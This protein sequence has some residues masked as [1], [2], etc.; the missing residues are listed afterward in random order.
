MDVTANIIE[1]KWKKDIQRI[2]NDLII[3][4][5]LPDKSLHIVTNFGRDKKKVTSYSLCIYEP[6]YPP[7]L[8]SLSEDLSRNSVILNIKEHAENL[9]FI[10][11]AIQFRDIDLPKNSIVKELKSDKTNVHLL[12]PKDYEIYCEYVKKNTE[13]ALSKYV[14]KAASFG[15]CS[16]FE[17]CSDSLKCLHPNKLYSTACTYRHHLE[18]G[19]IFYGKNKNIK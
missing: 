11:N 7:V 6:E 16:S 1:P 2:L 15:C 9:E 12:V 5:E 3:E 4:K 18:A 17:A 8:E 19:E 13:Y 14:S 10:I